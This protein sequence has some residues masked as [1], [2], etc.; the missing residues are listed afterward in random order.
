MA[1][2]K[3]HFGMPEIRRI[4][5]Q[6]RGVFPA[7]PTRRFEAAIAKELGALELMAR[8]RLAC[9]ALR[10]CLPQD[11]ATAIDILARSLG[12][13]LER[14]EG[15][16]MAPFL[17]LPHSFFIATFGLDDFEVSMR[18]QHELTRRFT[19]EF[20]MRPFLER[21]PERTLARLREWTRDPNVHVRRLVSEG[22]RPRLPWAPRLD[23]FIADPMPV[24]GLLELL[25]DD[26]EEYVRR[27]VANSLNDIG[28]D[29]PELLVA[30]ARRWLAD[31]SEQRRRLVRHALRTAVKRGDLQALELLG[32]GKPPD[33][34]IARTEIHPRRPRI[35]GS[36]FV[37]AELV[38]TGRG[39]QQINADVRIHFV[40]ANGTTR[41]KIFK[42][43]SFELGRGLSVRIGKKISLADMTTRRHHPGR[44]AVE[45]LV[46][47][48]VLPLGEF[49][50][51]PAP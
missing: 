27:S 4:A 34:R 22:T 25:K 1:A 7:F 19:A 35:G 14:T 50:L 37:G 5:E 29:H 21:H 2:L 12:E 13:E 18:A 45:L 30:T 8:G 32:F 17:Y 31:A 6:I 42:L 33:V 41:V 20:S 39:V 36:V 51:V 26:P 16:G 49:R 11:P 44:H 47:G 48:R 43:A 38:G 15:N 46:N 10:D 28:K 23:A 3:D 24:L 40:K 9:A